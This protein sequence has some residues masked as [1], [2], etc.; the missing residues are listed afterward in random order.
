MIKKIGTCGVSCVLSSFLSCA[1]ILVQILVSGW[2][3]VIVRLFF[4]VVWKKLIQKQK[5]GNIL[6]VI[7]SLSSFQMTGN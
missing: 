3:D 2:H 1:A 7:T 5:Q 4:F 6:K